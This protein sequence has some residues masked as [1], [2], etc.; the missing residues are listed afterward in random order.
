MVCCHNSGTPLHPGWL[1]A[2]L[3]WIQSDAS[4]QTSD[5][6]LLASNPF[7]L[8]TSFEAA[9]VFGGGGVFG[10][11]VKILGFFLSNQFIFGICLVQGFVQLSQSTA[12]WTD[13]N[14]C[15]LPIDT[16]ETCHFGGQGRLLSGDLIRLCCQGDSIRP[17]SGGSI[18]LCCQ[19]D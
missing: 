9:P 5:E 10:S 13:R 12:L 6:H 19:E 2:R 16:G 17:C 7:M 8:P 14:L 15:A 3:H 18:H 1:S 4:F 11:L